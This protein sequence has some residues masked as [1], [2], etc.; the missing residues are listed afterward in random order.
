MNQGEFLGRIS[1]R[2]YPNKFEERRKMPFGEQSVFISIVIEL[3]SIGDSSLVEKEF[4]RRWTLIRR[5][6]DGEGVL[7]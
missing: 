7:R 6:N 2:G 3:E 4:S 5:R 1:M